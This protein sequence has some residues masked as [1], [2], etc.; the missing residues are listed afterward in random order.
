M[1]PEDDVLDRIDALVDEQMAGGEPYGYDHGTTQC[2]H[3]GCLDEWHGL[4]TGK[5]P[6]SS[7][8]GPLR[9]DLVVR[10][11]VRGD[12]WPPAGPDYSARPGYTMVDLQEL[13]ER[14][15]RAHAGA[16]AGGLPYCGPSDPND[17]DSPWTVIAGQLDPGVPQFDP[18]PPPPPIGPAAAAVRLLLW[19]RLGELAG[20]PAELFRWTGRIVDDAADA[21][22]GLGDVIRTDQPREMRFEVQL[23]GVSPDLWRLLQGDDPEPEPET[24]Q[25]RALPRPSTTPPMWAVQPNQRPRRRNR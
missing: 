12:P 22:G 21:L 1:N 20:V 8:Y 17:L 10:R 16:L 2:P 15:S 14:F 23:E 3:D 19:Q 13:R 5:C 24:P 7:T 11:W 4:P 9:P 6:G 25:Q 18:P